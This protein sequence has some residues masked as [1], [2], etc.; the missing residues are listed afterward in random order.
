MPGQR[1][2]WCAHEREADHTVLVQ[3][4]RTASGR[5]GDGFTILPG[6]GAAGSVPP[7]YAHDHHESRIQYTR[8][9]YK[10]CMAHVRNS[11]ATIVV[12]R[13]RGLREETAGVDAQGLQVSVQT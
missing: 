8:V 13:L 7:R 9:F 3:Q 4:G 6:P 12:C 11:Y 2:N 1:P 10:Y 5:I